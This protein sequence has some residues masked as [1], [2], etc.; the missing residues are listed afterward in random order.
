LQVSDFYDVL[1]RHA[2]KCAFIISRYKINRKE[3]TRI[4][5]KF[6][7]SKFLKF[8]DSLSVIDSESALE[9]Y[10]SKLNNENFNKKILEYENLL[11]KVIEISNQNIKM[12][13]KLIKEL[14]YIKETKKLIG[15]ALSLSEKIKKSN[16][17]TSSCKIEEISSPISIP[18]NHEKIISDFNFKDEKLLD[19]QFKEVKFSK[20]K[21]FDDEDTFL[22]STE[23]HKKSKIKTNF[24]LEVEQ[25]S[26]NAKNKTHVINNYIT[27]VIINFN[28]TSFDSN[29]ESTQNTIKDSSENIIKSSLEKTI[30]DSSQNCHKDVDISFMSNFKNEIV[31][32]NR[33]KTFFEIESPSK[34]KNS[35][36]DNRIFDKIKKL[37]SKSTSCFR[38][39]KNFIQNT[40]FQNN[41]KHK[42]KDNLTAV[43]KIGVQSFPI[44]K[45]SNLNICEISKNTVVD[46]NGVE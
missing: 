21:L 35:E 11:S 28:D 39:D 5:E 19:D 17:K 44:V 22:Y 25:N 38:N 7:N 46:S 30:K 13:I 4:E 29:K 37:F 45:M 33:F 1:K 42:L 32:E 20:T 43:I 34:N 27:N 10:Y 23:S 18:V 6:K 36:N 8:I 16:L 12:T 26:E 15:Q 9:N 31:L 3:L 14:S 40:T 2:Q 24:S 41:S